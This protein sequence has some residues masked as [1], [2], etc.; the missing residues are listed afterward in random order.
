MGFHPTPNPTHPLSSDHS[1]TLAS[2]N[3]SNKKFF[4]RRP[5]QYLKYALSSEFFLE[6]LRQNIEWTL[7][8]L[9]V[10]LGKQIIT[11]VF[12]LLQFFCHILFQKAAQHYFQFRTKFCNNDWSFDTKKECFIKKFKSFSYTCNLSSQ[13]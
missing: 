7:L 6:P 4:L 3:T 13:L 12:P 11:R 9:R 2:C 1:I 8:L 5:K 10:V